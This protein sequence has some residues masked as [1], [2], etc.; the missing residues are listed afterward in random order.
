MPHFS[1]EGKVAIV[2]GGSKGIGR[3]IALEF[4]AAGADVALAARGE[5]ELNLVAKEIQERDRR[6]IVVPTD[7]SDPAQIQ[8]L[9]DRTVGEL[10][11]LDV[12]VNNAGSAPF[13]STID[14]IRESGFEK[15]FRVNFLSAFYATRYAAPH[16]LKNEGSSVVNVASV[17]GYIA[18]P[19][20]TYYSTAKAAMINLT[21]TVAREWANHGVRVNAVAPGWI[22]SEMNAEARK[23]DA[24]YEGV[25][26][27]VPMGRWGQPEEVAAV[28]RF[29]ASPAASFMTGS[30]VI[31]DGGQ[32]LASLV[33]S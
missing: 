11:K 26:S 23:S 16:L 3:A 27:M 30:V 24:F 5:E 1:L 17:A 7:V 25:V 6:A 9:I 8:A 18:S 21:K 31:V 2:T 10:G 4:A 33:G 19:G 13:F 15:Y 20:L 22:E 32:T 28:V 14:T 12:L 29:L